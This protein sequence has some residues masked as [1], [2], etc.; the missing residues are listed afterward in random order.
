MKINFL[1]KLFKRADATEQ[2]EVKDQTPRQ[3]KTGVGEIRDR[4]DESRLSRND[5]FSGKQ[6]SGEELKQEQNYN[7]V[8]PNDEVL[9]AFETGETRSSYVLGNLWSGSGKPPETDE[10]NENEKSEPQKKDS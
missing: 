10:R 6:L 3:I 8:D 7:R 4:F 2:P 1:E 9:V 5:F